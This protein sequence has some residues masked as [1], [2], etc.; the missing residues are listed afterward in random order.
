MV[1]VGVEMEME[2]VRQG[3]GVRR[4]GSGRKGVVGGVV[5]GDDDGEMVELNC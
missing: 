2:M 5:E 1:G 4:M 3:S